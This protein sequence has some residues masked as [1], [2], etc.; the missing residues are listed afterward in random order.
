MGT[1]WQDLRYGFRMLMKRPGF[2]LVAV[3]TLALG[4]GANTA[5]FSGVSAFIL[6]PLP[7]EEPGRLYRLFE[8]R[9]GECEFCDFSY[10]G[11]VDYRDQ[12]DVFEGLIGHRL[13]Q[14]ALSDED[15]NDLAWGELVTGNYFDVLRVRPALGRGFLPEEDKTPGSHPVVV[16]SH[17]LWANRFASDPNVVGHAVTMNGRPYT[18][19]GIAPR[20]FTGTMFGLS[21]DYWVPM[22]MQAHVMPGGGRLDERGDHWF[23][24]TGR[25][26]RGV[27][28]ERAEA[29]LS[30]VARRIDQEY[31][32]DRRIDTKVRVV[33][34]PEGRFENSAGTI[35]LGAG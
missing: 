30:T 21:M 20:G 33:P 32:A 16:L 3:V 26:K 7:V 2:T 15:R 31:R 27:T 4:I 12:N 34:E 28:R 10:P 23:E 9:G 19:V 8:A 5:I 24:V 13:I 17:N 29:A 14:V 6:R 18:V 25:L 22:M 35:T 1:L 11:Y